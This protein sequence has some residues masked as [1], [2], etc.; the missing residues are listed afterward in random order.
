MRAILHADKKW[1]IG[2]GNKLMFSIPRDMRFFRETTSGKV[3]VMGRNT[4]RSFPGG[5]PLKNRTNIVLS[6]SDAGEG[7]ITVHSEEELFRTLRRYPTDDV[8]VI[9]GAEV[10]RRLL[11]YCSEALVTRVEADG[12]ADTFAP[13]LDADEN[14]QLVRE[15]EPVVDGGYTLAFCTYRNKSPKPY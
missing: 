11:P 8:Y 13:D 5:K 12:G 6:H 15:S 7:A 3:V 9:G 4:L 10:Y 14:F 1:G 2:R